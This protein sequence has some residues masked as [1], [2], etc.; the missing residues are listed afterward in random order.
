MTIKK[1]VCTTEA[2]C[3]A[4]AL[5]AVTALPA[6]VPLQPNASSD[7]PRAADSWLLQDILTSVG[8]AVLAITVSSILGSQRRAHRLMKRKLLKE[9][10]TAANGESDDGSEVGSIAEETPDLQSISETSNDLSAGHVDSWQEDLRKSQNWRQHVKKQL[11]EGEG[12][13]EEP[14]EDPKRKKVIMTSPWRDREESP[15]KTPP[16]IAPSHGLAAASTNWR[17]DIKKVASPPLPPPSKPKLQAASSSGLSAGGSALLQL[18]REEK[19]AKLTDGGDG[20][21]SAAPPGL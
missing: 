1:T 19:R 11:P 4:A 21:T 3:I 18:L 13:E 16:P 15:K 6:V 14:Q 12:K 8:A 10:E 2:L 7:A 17:A 5:A 9:K 20:T